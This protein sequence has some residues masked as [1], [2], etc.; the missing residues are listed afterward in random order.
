MTRSKPMSRRAALAALLL[1]A[2]TPSG[3]RAQELPAAEEILA[4]FHAAVG[5]LE[6]LRAVSFMRSSGEYA[7]PAAGIVAQFEAIAAR[8]NLRVTTVTVPGFGEIR[9]GF[10]GTVGWSVNPAEG[11]RV[12]QGAEAVQAADD[13]MFDANFRLPGV[14]RAMTTI[15]KTTM[16]GRECYSVRMVF[17]SGRETVDCYDTSTFLLVGGIVSQASRA[18]TAEAVYTWDEYRD[19]D[20]VLLPTRVTVRAAGVDQV[21][22]R[23][24]VSFEPLPAAA[25]EA[26]AAIRALLPQ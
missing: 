9:T 12:M 22:T 19:F 5:G 21:L 18:G 15:E 13:A 10:D 1:A 23:S 2:F 14:Y 3:A 8:P 26:P 11:P 24:A 6:R 20:G 17:P 25:F 4:R 16:A 7:V